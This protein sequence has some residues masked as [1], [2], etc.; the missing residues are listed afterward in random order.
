MAALG[1]GQIVGGALAL[2]WRP[3]RPLLIVGAGLALTGLPALLLVL[4]ASEWTITAG[5]VVLGIEWGL[6]DPFWT[7][8][9]Q[10]R[11]A[12]DLISR[13]SSYDY[14]G[15]LAFYPLGLAVAGPLSAWLGVSTVLWLGVAAAVG[16]AAFLVSLPGVRGLRRADVT[17][18]L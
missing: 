15:S 5:M 7:T 10:Q 9:M 8:T 3:A 1:L 16:L 13:V 12:P 11:V 2:R 6:Y 14:M 4:G 18:D 17:A